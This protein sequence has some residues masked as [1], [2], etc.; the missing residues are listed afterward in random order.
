[1]ERVTPR[2]AAGLIRAAHR[3]LVTGHV[4]PDGDVLGSMTALGLGLR[5]AAIPAD[6]WAAT[7]VPA[8]Y[9]FLEPVIA[10][11]C[12]VP[13]GTFDLCVVL[14]TSTIARADIDQ[15]LIRACP[16]IIALDH[17]PEA[18]AYAT[19]ACID[20]TVGATAFLVH[21][22]LGEL[23]IAITPAIANAL[24]TG[25]LTDTG[26]FTY[27]NTD[28]RAFALALD[29]AD[30]GADI[31]GIAT[32][33][34]NC[35]TRPQVSLLAEML[36]TLDLVTGGRGALMHISR[37]MFDRTGATEADMEEFVNYARAIDCVAV[38]ALVTELPGGRQVRLSLRS[39]SA[40]VPVNTLAARYGGGGHVCAAGATVDSA[41]SSF[42]PAFRPV[43]AAFAGAH[44][45]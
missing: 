37:T 27:S 16:V 18:D 44:H 10:L 28:R 21:S 36:A 26:C 34:Y 45:S 13:A 35:M 17:H 14:D 33:I 20:P 40:E 8:R 2:Q 29:L 31:S 23:G 4:R 3:V 41:L 19:H 38:A 15:S 1:M 25:L 30:A 7:P 42:L 24:Y 22:L 39:K 5:Q 11:P 43:L 6:V 9:S 12:S 32:R